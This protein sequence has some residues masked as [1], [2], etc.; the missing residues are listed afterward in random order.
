MEA[1]VKELLSQMTLEEKVALTVGSGFWTTHA[2]PRLGVPAI[3]M[4]DGPT[5]VRRARPNARNPLGEDLPATCFPT[6]S[7]LAA[8]WDVE[9]VR[10][11]GAAI[12]AECQA[13]DVQLLLAPG[14]NMKRSPLCGRN[15]EYF[16]EDPVLA[17]ELAAAY[18][19]GVQSQ[20]VGA[21]VKHYAVNNQEHERFTV[22]AEVDERPLREIYLA[23]FERVVKK[24]RPWAVMAAYNQVNGVPACEHHELLTQILRKEWGFDG[25]VVSDWGAVTRR[26][27]SLA[28]GLDLQM[29]GPDDDFDAELVRMVREGRLPEAVVDEAAGRVLS[30]VLRAA[31]NRRSGATLDEERHHQLARRAAAE[32]IVLLKNEGALLPIRADQIRT[33]AVVGRFAW[34]PRFQGGGSSHVN[35]TRVDCA[36]DELRKLLPERVALRYAPGYP[37]EDALDEALLAE[38]V[39]AARSADMAVLFVGLPDAYESEGYDRT[40]IDLPPAHNQLIHAVCRAQPRTAVV[41]ANGA[42]VAMPWLDLPAAILEAGLGGQAGGGAVAD[43]LLGRVNPSGRLAETYPVCLEQTPAYLNWPGENGRVRYGEGLFIGYRYYEKKK[44]KPL[45]PFG[46]G[47]SYTTFA[48]TGIALSTEEITDQDDLV[49]TVT[50]RNTGNRAGKEV[51]QLYVRDIE[52]TRVRPVK[53]LKAFAKVALE[54]GQEKQV[55]FTLTGRDLATWC[56]ERHDWC[57]ESGAFEILVGPSSAETPLRAVVTVTSTAAPPVFDESTL[58]KEFLRHPVAAAELRRLTGPQMQAISPMTWVFIQ[59]MPLRRAVGDLFRGR[60]RSELD[61]ITADLVRQVNAAVQAAAG[62]SHA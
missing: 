16:S 10:E 50:L 13:L 5:G 31:A 30:L 56:P 23:V 53:E 12:G 11:V 18:V 46:Y 9:L 27:R 41:L 26:D 33:L 52:S 40:H 59:D 21:T 55:R 58:F 48:Y 37:A 28:A 19:Q 22:S 6:L 25:L 38:A 15:F 54:P 62:K 1:R 47:L 2:V 35:A 8:T 17:G 45:F 29:P 20:G 34:E 44:E 36:Y 7:T 57:V 42:P 14:V 60:S 24:A 3:V 39:E 61:A 4:T 49:V 51:V 43:V 32:A